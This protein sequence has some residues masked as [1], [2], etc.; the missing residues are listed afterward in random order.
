MLLVLGNFSDNP[1]PW[2]CFSPLTAITFGAAF[3]TMPNIYHIGLQVKTQGLYRTYTYVSIT[4]YLCKY[5]SCIKEIRK[6]TN[7]KDIPF[8]GIKGKKCVLA[9]WV[10]LLLLHKACISWRGRFFRLCSFT[11]FHL[12][13]VLAPVQM[14]ENML[15]LVSLQLGIIY[16]GKLF[17][18]P[19]FSSQMLNYFG[20]K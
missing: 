19:F 17:Q 16:L 5:M 18:I 13:I 3:T 10:W 6:I 7:K 4:T 20:T 1:F 11:L 15:S 9:F 8:M 14:W 2:S 12:W